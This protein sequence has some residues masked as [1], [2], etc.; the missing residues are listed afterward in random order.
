M[1]G[2]PKHL[3]FFL[4]IFFDKFLDSFLAMLLKENLAF[5]HWPPTGKALQD[6]TSAQQT[7]LGSMKD[8]PRD[9]ERT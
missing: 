8:V 1:F 5:F 9:V 2:F 3:F 6:R 4:F 7:S